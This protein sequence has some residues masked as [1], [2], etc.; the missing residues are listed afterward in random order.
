[1]LYAGTR[2]FLDDVAI[3]SVMKFEAEFIEF[4]NNTKSAVLDA[5][6]E[7]QKIDDA[8]EADL[9]AAIEEFKK[10]FSA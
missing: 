7:K 1:M 8:V 3:E 4:M 2:G 10:G 9:K 5:I 6:A